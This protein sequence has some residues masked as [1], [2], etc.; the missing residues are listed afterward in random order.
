VK[1]FFIMGILLLIRK[2]H[3]ITHIAVVKK[4]YYILLLVSAAT[5]LPY[6]VF[7]QQLGFVTSTPRI[8]SFPKI[9]LKMTATYNGSLPRPGILPSDLDIKEDNGPVSNVQLTDCDESGQAAVVFCVDASTSVLASAGDTWNIFPSYFNS[10]AKFISAIPAASKYALVA[11]TDQIAYYP[12]SAVTGGFYA[13]QNPGDSSA[14]QFNL[15]NQ[16]FKGATNVDQAMDFSVGLLKY[17]PF[18]QKAIVLV[19]DDGVVDTPYFDSLLNALNITLYVMQLGADGSPLNAKLAHTTGGVYMRVLTPDSA[20]HVPT[21]QQLSELVFGE[22]CMLRY[23]STNPCPWVHLHDISL[24]LNYKSLSRNL[25]EQYVL[26]RNI[27]DFDPPLITEAIP[28]YT[29]RLVTATEN[30]PC[31]RG[32][33]IFTDSLLINIKKISFVRKFPNYGSDSLSVVDSLQPARAVYIAADSANNKS[34]KEILYTPKPDILAPDVSVAQSFGGKYLMLVTEVRPWDRGLKDITL[35]AG[36][37]NLILDSIKL[38][39]RRVGQ[40]W[41]HKI[42]LTAAT[43]GCIN[44][45]DSSGN[46]GSYCIRNDSTTGDTL[47]PIIKQDPVASPRIA[48]TGTVT[49]ERFKDIGIK[50]VSIL[51]AANIGLPVITFTNAKHVVFTVPILDSL[52]PVRAPISAADSVGNATSDV[53]IYDPEPDFNAPVC[54]VEILDQKTRMFHVSETAPWDR[55]IA[56]VTLVTAANN[57][58]VGPVVFT[59]VYHAQQQFTVIDPFSPASAVV[60]AVDSANHECET[61][62]SIDPLF[63]PLI[64]FTASTPVDFGTV[65]APANTSLPV[66][67]T[68]PNE[69]SVVVTKIAQTGDIAIFSSDMVTPIAFAPFEKKIFNINFHPSLL[70]SWQ[71][72]WTISNDTMLLA[73]VTAIGRSIGNVM[74][75]IDSVSVPKT[76]LKSNFTVSISATPAPIN[77][78]SISFV[79]DYDADLVLLQNPVVNCAS[80]N[81]PLCNYTIIPNSLSTGKIEYLLKRIDRTITN[82]LDFS[83]SSFDVS[84]TCFVAKKDTTPLLLE[85]LFVSQLSTVSYSSGRID[86]GSQCGDQT[87]RAYLNGTLPAWIESIVPNPANSIA[88]VNIISNNKAD[89]EISLVNNLGEIILRKNITIASG[90]NSDIINLSTIRSG[91]YQLIL[92]LAGENISSRVIEIVH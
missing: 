33:R 6:S 91:N 56:S 4:L 53:L 90:A 85:N 88:T 84:F 2:E 36:S 50:S 76:Q 13:G 83:T 28:S 65:Y 32:M 49:E 79:L 1:A 40:A 31:T 52:Q 54:S 14:F 71:S 74:I 37:Q 72:K 30:Y 10:Y 59:D 41:L 29:S 47:G 11:F 16:L 27:F 60:K 78:D 38:I 3:A 89:G 63:K 26:G 8:D 75:S 35:A 69:S 9:R 70:G 5:L 42:N 45:I 21:M 20:L 43:S 51:S 12:A 64:P 57:L 82:S 68:N 87:L 66:T 22:H 34:R 19:T 67:I 73:S 44:G 61:T 46:I 23:L 39:S 25:I 17:Q 80:G 7:A 58:T 86:V 92:S 48:I 24:T 62:I 77:L 55:G 81:N 15:R 18:K